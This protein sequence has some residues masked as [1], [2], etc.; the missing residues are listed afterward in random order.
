MI[1]CRIHPGGLAGIGDPGW[2]VLER[3]HTKFS[4]IREICQSRPELDSALVFDLVDAG[5]SL[6]HEL[7]L[8]H[9]IDTQLEYGKIPYRL[10]MKSTCRGPQRKVSWRRLPAS[11]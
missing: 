8:R 10:M 1:V 9:D 6:S 5:S 7:R 3:I 4:D 11:I 2:P